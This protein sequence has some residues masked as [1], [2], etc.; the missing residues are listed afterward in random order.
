MS[1]ICVFYVFL[2]ENVY[3]LIWTCI[4]GS[5]RRC[6]LHNN[7]KKQTGWTLSHDCLSSIT[8]NL[9]LWM[10]L[11]VI[12]VSVMWSN[13]VLPFDLLLPVCE[14][15]RQEGCGTGGALH[16]HHLCSSG[17]PCSL[18]HDDTNVTTLPVATKGM[19]IH[20]ICI[21]NTHTLHLH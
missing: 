17:S 10:F 18:S 9:K 12:T 4:L 1:V 5:W 8:V 13:S 15:R 20:Y 14:S 7:K 21:Y 19:N 3:C 2:E 16:W 6:R 11:L